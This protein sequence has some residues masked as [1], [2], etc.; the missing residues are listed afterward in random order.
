MV[1]LLKRHV[2]NCPR[3]GNSAVRAR[4]ALVIDLMPGVNEEVYNEDKPVCSSR[5]SE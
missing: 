2:W 3:A 4:A 5:F 1:S